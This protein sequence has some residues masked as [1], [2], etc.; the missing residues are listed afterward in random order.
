M[1]NLFCFTLLT[2]S[3]SAQALKVVPI[4]QPPVAYPEFMACQELSMVFGD[5]PLESSV[6][7]ALQ[8][9]QFSN[10]IQNPTDNK[11]IVDYSTEDKLDFAEFNRPEM[12]DLNF[13]AVK[14]IKGVRSLGFIYDN[15]E[16]IV[17]SMSVLEC[18]VFAGDES[19]VYGTN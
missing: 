2:L 13:G 17:S 5:R 1:K 16:L 18:S 11:F 3:I 10:I 14:A 8:D 9:R 15:S 6:M 7:W 19:L 12:H 4:G